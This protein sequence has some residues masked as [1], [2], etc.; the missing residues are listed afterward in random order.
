MVVSLLRPGYEA[1]YEGRPAIH[2][3]SGIGRVTAHRRNRDGTHDILLEGLGRVHVDELPADAR[4]YRVAR[5]TRAKTLHGELPRHELA[6]LLSCVSRVASVV[7]ERH[8]D[9]EVGFGIDDDV[10]TIIDRIA[11]RFVSEPP[12][13]QEVLEALDLRERL[14]K[15]TDAVGDLLALIGAREE[16][17]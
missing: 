10:A 12:R 9:F 13:R 17:S 1:E 2:T 3:L 5:A 4:P 15:V 8:P 6:P 7:R 16:P 11:D 14:E